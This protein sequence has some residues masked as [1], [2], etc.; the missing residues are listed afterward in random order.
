MAELVVWAEEAWDNIS[1]VL[2]NA[3]LSHKNK[4]NL[5]QLTKAEV[6]DLEQ[7][8]LDV[9]TN[10]DLLSRVDAQSIHKVLASKCITPKAFKDALVTNDISLDTMNIDKYRRNIIGLFIQQN[11]AI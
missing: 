1:D 2:N 11:A 4:K 10:I 9:L 8:K 6:N 3:F 5:R 7:L